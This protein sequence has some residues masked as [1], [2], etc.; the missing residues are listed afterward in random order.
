VR[1]HQP[2]VIDKFNGL[3]SRGNIEETPLDHF[4]DCNNLRYVGSHTFG[5]R[6]GIGRHQDVASPLSSILRLY[7]FPTDD[8]NTLLVLTSG[9]NIYHVVDATTIHGPILTIAAMTDFGF[10]PYNGRAYITPFTT[11]VVGGLNIERGLTGE[12]VYVYLG[13]GTSARK[14]GANPPSGTVT[15]ANGAA[16]HT[17]AGD[18]VFGVVFE[19]DTG[20]LSAPA[21]LTMFTTGASNSVSFTNVP[22]SAQSFVTKRHI[23]ASKVIQDYNGDTTGYDLFF[24]PGATIPNNVGTSLSN[25]SFFDQDLLEDATH[26][27][28]NLSEIPAGVGL[29]LYHNRMCLWGEFANTSIIRVSA[30]GEPEA[31]N[32]ING[33]LEV[34][35]DGNPLT[36]AG[37]LRDVL[38]AFKRSRTVSFVDN[39][40]TPATWPLSIVDN[41]MGCGVHGLGTVLDSGASNIDYFVV[42]SYK[43]IILFNGRYILPELS[44][45]IQQVWTAQNF[46]NRNRVIQ[47]V[48]DP[49]KQ[50]IY[51]V[52]TDNT[53]LH[54]D[55]SNGFDPKAI[56]WS[57][58]TFDV[59]VNS[60]CLINISDLILGC[61]QV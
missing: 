24:I 55:Y 31:F 52:M 19:T 28:D 58:W 32:A 44:W 2:I 17:D 18:H 40:D 59:K 49:V 12:F 35:P 37:E 22:V 20:Y 6:F 9:G 5:T 14:A 45:K 33:L 30:A 60:L 61:D 43:G 39:G 34:P 53:V 56:R 38:Y 23:V 1:D 26:L 46:K 29:C 48:N 51:C 21:A 36:N 41:A 47:I 16:G 3:W 42:G 50:V 11:E 8:G 27:L 10:V 15:V 4:S 54:G 25:I 13:D 7:N 57:P